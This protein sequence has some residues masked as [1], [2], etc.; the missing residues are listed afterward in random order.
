MLALGR[1]YPEVTSWIR[2]NTNDLNL[3][4]DV[5]LQETGILTSSSDYHIFKKLGI[6]FAIFCLSG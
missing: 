3:M 2:A 4:K 5:G 6:S 1:R